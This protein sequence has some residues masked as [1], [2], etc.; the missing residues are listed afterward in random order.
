MFQ[1]RSKRTPKVALETLE[2]L[3]L[4]TLESNLNMFKINPINFV[5]KKCKLIKLA[6]PEGLLLYR[7]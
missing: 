1:K 7:Q 2:T 4:E 3:R 5:L 6:F